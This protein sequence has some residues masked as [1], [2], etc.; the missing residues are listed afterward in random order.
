MQISAMR[1]LLIEDNDS[2]SGLLKK[3]LGASGF[4]VD[5]VATVSESLAALSTTRF[6][7]IIL[8]LGLPDGE[9]FS[10]LQFLRAKGD[11]TPVL[12]LTARTAVGER[13]KGLRRGADD[14]LGK[15]FALEELVA[16]LEALLRRPGTLLGAEFRLGRLTFDTI[17]REIAVDGKLHSMPSREAT[18]LEA[19]LR[20]SGHVVPKKI[21]EDQIY[22]LSDDVSSNAVEVYVHR[23]RKQLSDAQADV[24]IH[25]IRGVGYLIQEKPP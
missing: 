12:I 16:R 13:V 11:P 14:Y 21:I 23:L 20:R 5:C 15:P 22:G 1:L 24:E 10:I 25:T 2:L 4:D 9:G 8:D 18:V 7:A 19:L 6:S 3:G 17:A